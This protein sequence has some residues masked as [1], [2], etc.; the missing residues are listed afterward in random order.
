MAWRV[1][2][3]A[4]LNLQEKANFIRLSR[5][6]VDKG[7]EALRMT[8]DAIHPPANLA[9]V[10]NANKSVLLKLKPRVINYNQWDLLFPPSGNSPD[11]KTFDITLLT[12]LLRNICGLHP[13][14]TGWNTMPPDT[15]NS[16]AANITRI[17][18]LRNEVYAHV[19][20]TETDNA[21]FENLWQ[22]VS[23]ALVDLKVPVKEIDDLKT[24]PLSPEEDI[25]VETLKEWYLKE[26]NCKKLIA[27]VN[28]RQQDYYDKSATFQ[29]HIIEEIQRLSQAKTEE[30]KNIRP[31]LDSGESEWCEKPYGKTEVELLPNLAKHN[32]KSKI[33]NKVKLF[34]P[35][36]REWLFEKVESWFTKEDESRILLIS[37]GP[38]FGKSVF[39]AKV[40]EI[41]KEND[42]F[43]A[44]HFC[45][46]SDSNLKNPMMMIQSLA[47]HMTENIPRYKE[48]LVDQLRRPHEVKSI[49]DAFQIYLQNPL[50]EIE[51]EPRLIVI[52]G[53]DESTAENKSEMVKLIS[54]RFPDLP[55]CVKVLITSRPEISLN[56]LEHIQTIEILKENEEC[57]LDLLKYLKD[58]LPRLAASDQEKAKTGQHL[59]PNFI[60]DLDLPKF[61]KYELLQI[62]LPQIV[63]KCEGSFLYAFHVQGELH[64]RQDLDSISTEEIMLFLPKGMGS[65]YEEYFHRLDEELKGI[66]RTKA[67]LYHVLEL[68]LAAI[69]FLPLRFVARALGLDLDCRKTVDIINKVNE[70]I[71]C[72]LFVSNEEVTV[73]HKTVRDW[74]LLKGEEIHRYSVTSA[75]GS[76]RMWLICEQVYQEIKSDV[77][78]GRELKPSKEVTHALKYGLLYLLACN[79]KESFDWLV[80][81]II[82]HVHF[83]FYPKHEDTLFASLHSALQVEDIDFRL[84][85]RISWHYGEMY[86][87]RTMKMRN[88]KFPYLE[89]VIDDSP[90]SCFTDDER[91]TAKL[92]L[93]KCTRYVKRYS[94]RKKSLKLFIGKIFPRQVNAIGLT[95]CK[96]LAAVALQDGTIH[97]VSLPNVVELF[98]HQTD[99]KN[100]SCCTFTPDDSIVL[101]G[102]LEM[103]LSVLKQKKISFFSG[104]VETFESCA[105]SPVGKRLVT[106]DGSS[107]VKLWDVSRRSLLLCLDAGVP[108]KS[109]SFSKNGLFITGDSKDT[110]E[111][112]YCVWNAIT[113]QRVDLRSLCRSRNTTNGGLQR[114]ERCNRCVDKVHKELTP[115]KVFG[116]SKG[117][118]NGMEC[119]FYSN[120]LASLFVRETTHYTI[121]AA[122]RHCILANPLGAKYLLAMINDNL[123]LV[124]FYSHLHIL[125]SEQPEDNQSCLSLPTLV[126]W[127]T[128]SP[129]GTRIAAYTSDGLIKLWNVESCQ[130]YERFR[131]SSD[132]LSG[133][134][135]WSKEYLF[136][137]HLQDGVPNLSKYPVEE[138]FG[139]KITQNISVSL[140]PII[141]DLLPLSGIQE[142]SE[143]Y[144]SF[145]CDEISPIK[146]VNVDQMESPA[147]VS[148]PE[149]TPKMSIVV[150]PGASLILG[151]DIERKYV[152]VWKRIEADPLSYL[153]HMKFSPEIILKD[154]SFFQCCFSDDLKFA[155][156]LEN[157]AS[158]CIYVDLVSKTCQPRVPQGRYI[159]HLVDARLF[160]TK[161]ILVIV[162]SS[163]LEIFDLKEFK[164]LQVIYAPHVTSTSQLNAKL[165]PNGNVLAV[166]TMTGEMDFFQIF[167]TG[168]LENLIT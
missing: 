132:I 147:M 5:L 106:N 63:K 157:A 112:S 146:V 139:I 49:K 83:T 133:A 66:L 44:C 45:D 22:K 115:S 117:M 87:R 61:M 8:F 165:S 74:L 163:V 14:S 58:K 138:K 97:V 68:L 94:G 56:A 30:P 81:M 109:C 67:D 162:S 111:D 127:C 135:W 128:F 72:I 167:H 126:I 60:C 92:L 80:D 75:D 57:D 149:I 71:S 59:I 12:V 85:Q 79:M 143:G 17:K 90:Q 101:Y 98:Q 153:V 161:G 164:S 20:S 154:I 19:S 122:W 13:P 3:M 125:I 113:F 31:R 10:L 76:K 21:T 52:D 137:C 120:H 100:I 37:A 95:S 86:R 99:C 34:H 89:L 2:V 18:L 65:I 129:D 160:F 110:K 82:L 73:F 29:Q 42:K 131:N 11:S 25:F 121:L 9:T 55:K 124:S 6:L 105:F 93:E 136:V 78:A 70:A 16:L 41:F 118:Y 107:T 148:L 150:A 123:W 46:Y 48:K 103:G 96:K 144:I 51:M 39:A 23:K 43:A 54:D 155:Y 33:R 38:G 77:I 142:F 88:L 28:I 152:I 108:L 40:C 84:R 159:E 140:L 102:K 7:C 116:T 158:R 62:V 27:E 50:D 1:S 47:S 53:L 64:K 26:E 145:A 130:V 141:S 69:S 151:Q 166:A 119:I 15:D 4:S 91:E 168:P 35:G 36:T 24:S 156:I 134:C 114:S 32:F 104:K